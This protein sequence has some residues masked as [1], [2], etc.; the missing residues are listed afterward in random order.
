MR[1]ATAGALVAGA[2]IVATA[3]G[4]SAVGSLD[5]TG[6]VDASSTGD[7]IAADGNPSTID[8]GGGGDA[9]PAND[10]GGCGRAPGALALYTFRDGTGEKASDVSG[11]APPLDLTI[12]QPNGTRWIDGGLAVDTT[13]LL[14]SGAATKIVSASKATNEVTVEVWITPST[15]TNGTIQR[16]TGISVDVP[17]PV[18]TIS[19]QNDSYLFRVRTSGQL[20]DGENDVFTDGG[21][22]L[23]LQHV[24][25]TRSA[26]GKHRGYV[27]GNLA[28]EHATNGDLSTWTNLAISVANEHTAGRPWLGELRLVAYYGRALSAAEVQQNFMCGP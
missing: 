13:S 14:F 20:N 17:D 15:K 25:M 4:I 1:N 5:A 23:A 6:G 3:C 16:I 22:A 26:D 18:V 2:I 21:V 12:Q 24:V 10:G 28:V 9:N 11:V 7:A 19:A 27:D 8:G